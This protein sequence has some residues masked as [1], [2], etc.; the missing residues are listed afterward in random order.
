ME[1]MEEGVGEMWKM[2]W[3]EVREEFRRVLGGGVERAWVGGQSGD[4]SMGTPL[5]GGS[6]DFPLIGFTGVGECM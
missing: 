6:G 3:N 1:V 4:M 5:I 2:G